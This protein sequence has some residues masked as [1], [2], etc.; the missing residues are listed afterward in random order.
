MHLSS[1][2]HKI[3]AKDD[4]LEITFEGKQ[5][6]NQTILSER[7]LVATGRV[8]NI[9]DLNLESTSIA[10]DRKGIA[11]N[12]Y[13]ETE[14]E[15]IYAVGDV[16]QGPKFAH[17]ATYEAMIAARNIVHGN[18]FKLNL[19]KNAWVL[20]SD[21]EIASAGMT[22]E[23]ALKQR[24]DIVTGTYDFK[25]DARA[26]I[27]ENPFGFLKFVVKRETEQI[28]GVHLFMKGAS[29]LAGE[30]ALIISMNATLRDVAEVIHPHPTLAESFGFLSK[31]M[32]SEIEK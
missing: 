32:L 2:V 27:S 4:M 29:N 18:R 22:E 31:K 12:E 7:V 24:L 20:F 8:P 28:I 5:G 14:E 13:L 21:P 17:T 6:K 15:G 26:Q 30:A 9:K 23:D 1:R 3:M 16:I 25:I 19:S 10:P 11:V